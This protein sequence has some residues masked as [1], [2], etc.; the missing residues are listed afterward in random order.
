MIEAL[1]RIGL[2]AVVA[3]LLPGLAACATTG[4][5]VAS[6][7]Q[8]A[9]VQDSAVDSSSLPPIG[10]QDGN[11]QVAGA[12]TDQASDQQGAAAN[13][14]DPSLAANG[15]AGE[16]IEATASLSGAPPPAAQGSFVSLSDYGATAAGAGVG[17]NLTGALTVDKLLGGWTVSAGET[18][19]RL[20]LTYTAMDGASDRYRA[21]APG[22]QLQAL[23]AVSSWQL[24]GTQVQLFNDASQL[25][26]T[27]LLTGDRFIGT[28]S[29][30]QAVTMVG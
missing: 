15:G 23:A 3:A 21:S 13:P 19:C 11:V 22:C 14:G 24:S 8:V 7:G 20:N 28:L 16:P 17:R 29:G 10:G 12:A 30:G 18:S 1:R 5:D 4:D 2:A 27:L 26:G 25:V 9:P 6:A